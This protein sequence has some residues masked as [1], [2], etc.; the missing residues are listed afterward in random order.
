[1]PSSRVRNAP[2][3]R[4]QSCVASIPMVREATAINIA[5]ACQLLWTEAK[6][7]R[8][9]INL[10]G[11]GESETDEIKQALEGQS[12]SCCCQSL[13]KVRVFQSSCCSYRWCFGLW[14]PDPKLF[15]LDKSS[16]RSGK[17]S[18]PPHCLP[19]GNQRLNVATEKGRDKGG[20]DNELDHILVSRLPDH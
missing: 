12:A 4:T 7:H 10:K 17:I 5:V 6:M 20:E 14:R 18:K 2:N 3:T 1:M 16:L 13:V 15:V 11:T 9:V 8:T 19:F